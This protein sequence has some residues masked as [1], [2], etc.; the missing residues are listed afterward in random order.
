M[1]RGYRIVDGPRVAHQA[2]LLMGCVLAAGL[3]HMVALVPHASG[4]VIVPAYGTLIALAG[5]WA[6]WGRLLWLDP[7]FVPGG[8]LN[9]ARAYWEAVERMPPA[10][11]SPDGFCDKSELRIPTRAGYSKLSLG[12]VRAFDHDCPWVERTIGAGNHHIFVLML[13][14][15]EAAI[16]MWMATLYCIVRQQSRLGQPS[17]LDAF[18]DGVDDARAAFG[19]HAKLALWGLPLMVILFWAL[20]PLLLF[21][22]GLLC[23]NVTTREHVHWLRA[24]HHR[25]SACPMPGSADWKLYAPHDR[26]WITNTLS[27]FRGLR[28]TSTVGRSRG[29][30]SNG[31]KTRGPDGDESDTELSDI[32]VQKPL[33]SADA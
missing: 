23:S 17:L 19:M 22:V 33:H 7:G 9:D 13:M 30:L 28:D 16:L 6:Q 1:A 18:A 24:Q 20:T 2:P 32:Y 4:A 5:F 8:D 12:M 25:Q 10:H 26:G 14:C 11:S 31:A 15:G 21:H 27:F 3:V 29:H